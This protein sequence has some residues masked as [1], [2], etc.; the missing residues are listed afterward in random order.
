MDTAEEINVVEW[1]SKL[2]GKELVPVGGTITDPLKQVI[3]MKFNW[4]LVN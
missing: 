1:E 3:D 2:V 4:R